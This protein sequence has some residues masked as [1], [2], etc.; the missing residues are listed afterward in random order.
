MGRSC[1]KQIVDRDPSLLIEGQTDRARLVAKNPA[2]ELARGSPRA[3]IH[4]AIVAPLP[5]SY[6]ATAFICAWCCF[7]R[8]IAAAFSAP[9]SNDTA[10]EL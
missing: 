8:S 4:A 7:T 5:R 2:Q 1:C 10:A 3:V 6:P 9:L